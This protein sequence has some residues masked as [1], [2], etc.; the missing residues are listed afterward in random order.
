MALYKMI[1]LYSVLY[2]TVLYCTVL[3]CNGHGENRP[4]MRR[5]LLI[6]L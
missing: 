5:S 4:R 3:Y 2:C 6:L 1:V